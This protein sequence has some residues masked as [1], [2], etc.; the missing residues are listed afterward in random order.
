M[1]LT[2][3]NSFVSK[4]QQ[5]RSTGYSAHLDLDSHAGEAWV[6]L[7][8]RHAPPGHL[9]HHLCQHH[10]QQ[11]FKKYDSPSCQRPRD[12]CAAAH[13]IGEAEEASMK[14]KAEEAQ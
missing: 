9:H 7:H 12:R 2:E 8:V 6:G 4:F 11:T 3:L 1:F 10:P 14:E 13:K 5:L